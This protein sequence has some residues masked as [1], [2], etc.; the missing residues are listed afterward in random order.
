[1]AKKKVVKK[2]K[3][4]KADIEEVVPA[5]KR[6]VVPK[7]QKLVALRNIKKMEAKGYK[8]VKLESDK[9]GR[10]LGVNTNMNSVGDQGNNTDLVL[11]E[12]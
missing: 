6:K 5:L 4:V 9:H 3:I 12:R 7:V 1:M 8:Q 10:T 11:M 2:E